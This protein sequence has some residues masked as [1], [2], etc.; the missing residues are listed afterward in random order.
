MTK[1]IFIFLGLFLFVSATSFAKPLSD[2]QKQVLETQPGLR[3]E[4]GKMI[5]SLADLDI[6]V[7]RDRV[8]DFEIF[9][10]DAQRILD[11][12][13]RIRKL[14]AGQVYKPFLDRLSKPTQKLLEASKIQDPRASKYPEEIFNAC[15]KC[16]QAHRGF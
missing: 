16:H 15:F 4:M 11:A 5:I 10:D 6:L 7:N 12:I 14:D 8:V 1:V 9:Q 2:K 13:A 3:D